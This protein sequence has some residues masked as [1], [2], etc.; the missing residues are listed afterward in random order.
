MLLLRHIADDLVGEH[1]PSM[2]LPAASPVPKG[3]RAVVVLLTRNISGQAPMPLLQGAWTLQSGTRRQH[4]QDYSSMLRS[5]FQVDAH[6]RLMFS[7]RSKKVKLLALV[8]SQH[9]TIY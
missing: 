7:V 8:V 9:R 4:E 3:L 1:R 6:G 5:V 2:S